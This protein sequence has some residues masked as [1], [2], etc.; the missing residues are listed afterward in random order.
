MIKACVIGLGQRGRSLVKS[1]LLNNPEVKIV[2]VCDLYEDRVQ[3]TL[4]TI[5]EAGGDARGFLDWREALNVAGLDA[6]FIFSDWNT[7]SEIAVYAMEKGI[8]AASEVGCEY[9][10]ENC[11][12]LVRTQEKTGTPYMFMENCCYNRNELLVTAMARHGLFG[13]IVHCSGAYAHDLREEISYGHVNRHYRFDNYLHRNCDNYP[14]H[15]LGPIAKILDINRGN[16]IL[17]VSSFASKSAGLEE[18][19]ATR[20]DATDEMKAAK[21][22]QG[23]I[24]TTVLTC[25]GGETILLRLDTTLPRSYDREFTVRGT[26]GLYM[27]TLNAVY[28]DCEKEYWSSSEYAENHLNNAKAYEEK[29]LPSMLKDITPE[30]KKAGH[31]GMDW[32]AYKAFTDA[33]KNGTPMP[34]DVYDGAVWQAVSV[35]SEMSIAQGGAPQAMPDF[36]GGKWIKRPRLDVCEM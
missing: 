25:A 36:T 19:I 17:T 27:Q 31:G 32:F 34:I 22:K 5:S 21:F 26:K 8:A 23:D 33:L 9:S 12:A 18:Y 7:H 29:Y 35:L 11:N 10:L 20:E 13:T 2:S 15:E 6:V 28:L 3:K 14:T 24:V 4:K 1:V 16:R 30:Q